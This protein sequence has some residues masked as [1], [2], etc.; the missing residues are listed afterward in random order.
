MNFGSLFAGIGGMD[1]G[2]ER[3]GMTCK[4][5]VEIDPFCQKVLTRHWPDVRRYED[6]RTVGSH[7]LEP[8]ELIV[9]GFPCQ[10]HSVAGKRKGAEDDRNLWPEFLRIVK[11][12]RPAW[13]LAENVPGIISLYL[14]TV[15]S[16]LEGEGYTCWTLNIPACA[17]N[18]PHIRRRIFVVAYSESERTPAAEQSRQG[19][20]PITSSQDVADT[21]ERT[22]RYDGQD[23]RQ[24][25]RKSNTLD[26]AGTSGRK[27]HWWA[28]EPAVG[29]VAHGIPNRVDRLRNLGNAVVPQV[30]EW[31][32]RQIMQTSA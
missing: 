30:A 17:F 26:N 31:I 16:D 14:D 19:H 18:A 12:L 25:D 23:E 29:R 11:E 20:G 3:A 28:T 1:L 24:T 10:P 5:Q 13:V 7:N 4:W 32:G 15:L 21:Q 6:V 8:V 9:G 27:P 22:V 2:L